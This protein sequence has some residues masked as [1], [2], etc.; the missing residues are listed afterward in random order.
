MRRLLPGMFTFV[1]LTI[2]YNQER[3]TIHINQGQYTQT[4]LRRFGLEQAND[5]EH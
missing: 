4:I 1:G 3:R 2:Q 5:P